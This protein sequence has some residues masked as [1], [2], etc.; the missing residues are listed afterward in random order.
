MLYVS[1]RTVT[2]TGLI[3][4]VKWQ[5]YESAICT[6]AAHGAEN[7]NQNF[8]IPGIL[9][10]ALVRHFQWET[11]GSFQAQVNTVASAHE[12]GFSKGGSCQQ[13]FCTSQR[14]K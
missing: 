10:K 9:N 5:A 11:Q 6:V 3:Y 14:L 13:G 8:F 2:R 12:V 4:L 1:S 7:D